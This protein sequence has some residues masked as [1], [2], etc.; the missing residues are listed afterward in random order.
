MGITSSK[1][2]TLIS[3]R[4]GINY[5]SISASNGLFQDGSF[6]M[7]ALPEIPMWSCGCKEPSCEVVTSRKC[8]PTCEQFSYFPPHFSH[9]HSCCSLAPLV[10]QSISNQSVNK[11]SRLK[12]CCLN[13]S[14][15]NKYCRLYGLCVIWE[16][17]FPLNTEQT[18]WKGSYKL[19]WPFGLPLPHSHSLKL[20]HFCWVPAF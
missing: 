9:P 3:V 16:E 14:I 2:W 8:I 18:L 4:P 12:T 6:F 5:L 1:M 19:G 13:P 7:L 10:K 11:I 15:Y 17:V 20:S